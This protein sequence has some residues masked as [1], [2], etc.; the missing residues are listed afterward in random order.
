MGVDQQVHELAQRTANFG[1]LLT[2]EPVLVVH[3][4]AAEA[5]VFT[6]PNTAMFKCRLF[7]E[8]LTA[9]AFIQ[10]GIPN[11]PDKQFKRLKILSDQGLI[12]QRVHGWF[13]QVRTIGNQAVHEGYAAQRDALLLVRACY[14]LG[15]WFSRTVSG[16]RDAAPPFVSPQPSAAPEPVVAE[17]SEALAELRQLLSQY[18]AELVEMKTTIDDRTARATAEVAAQAAASQEI[19]RAVQAQAGLQ[20]LVRQLSTKVDELQRQLNAKASDAAPIDSALRDEYVERAAIAS[21]PLLSEAQVRR[22]IDRM[23]T[24]AGWVVQDRAAMNV[25]AKLGVAV[26]EVATATGRADY[27]LYVGA[28]LVGVIEA[29]REGVSLGAVN[30][31]TERYASGL[32]AGQQLAA[33]RTPLPFRYESTAVETRFTNTLD[34]VG[35]PRRLFSFHQPATIARWIREAEANTEAPTYRHRL[36][37]M[38]ELITEDLRKAQVEAISGL[39]ASLADD[40]PRALIQMAT[41]GGQDVHDGHRDLP[42]APPRGGEARAVSGGPQQ[43]RPPGAR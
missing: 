41:G 15:A 43:P 36:R 6:D 7:G 8:A 19:L 34:P 28:K 14:E 29:K 33:W 1:H 37:R 31:Q 26:R 27:L 38:P 30:R 24:T 22:I 3:G 5:A 2:H 35:R 39:E 17:E 9:R 12:N 16:S 18:H 32:D 42:A 23:L 13:E 40:K 20:E 25:H 21:R 10:F 11:M 4:A